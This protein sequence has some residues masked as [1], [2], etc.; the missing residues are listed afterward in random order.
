MPRF[1][2]V[3]QYTFGSHLHHYS[4]DKVAHWHQMLVLSPSWR[5]SSVKSAKMHHFRYLSTF[6]RTPGFLDP[7]RRLYP[8][9]RSSQE[10]WRTR[11]SCTP[12]MRD[13]GNR[14]LHVEPSPFIGGKVKAK[15]SFG[16]CLRNHWCDKR[17]SCIVPWITTR[18]M[19]WMRNVSMWRTPALTSKQSNDARNIH[20]SF[21]VFVLEKRKMLKLDQLASLEAWAT[22][23]TRSREEHGQ[24][25]DEEYSPRSP[26]QMWMSIGLKWPKIPRWCATCAKVSNKVTTGWAPTLR[27]AQDV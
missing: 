8:L 27:I 2:Q 26:W 9:P 10:S 6:W 24:I 16:P 25:S 11:V 1:S 19:I 22:W 23:K 12:P 20:E 18:Y 4:E 5:T 14:Y 15:K 21:Q 7:N 13:S 17:S 3:W